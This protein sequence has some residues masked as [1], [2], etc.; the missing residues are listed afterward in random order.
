MLGVGALTW[1][2]S[3][4]MAVSVSAETCREQYWAKRLTWHMPF[5]NTH[6]LFTKRTWKP[7]RR[8]QKTNRALTLTPHPLPAASE[9]YPLGGFFRLLSSSIPH[10]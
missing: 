2:R 1:W 7:T 6:V 5:P 3:T 9:E 8:G 4:A 10:D